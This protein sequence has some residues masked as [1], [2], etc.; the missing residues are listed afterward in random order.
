MVLLNK[1]SCLLRDSI[2][3]ILDQRR[4]VVVGCS[5]NL[6]VDGT[7]LGYILGVLRNILDDIKNL[8]R[9]QQSYRTENTFF[10]HV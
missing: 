3:V 10:I 2:L 9:Y 4:W 1:I 5:C 6:Y 8:P 7:L